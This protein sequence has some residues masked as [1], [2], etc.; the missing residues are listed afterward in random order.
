MQFAD[1][2]YEFLTLKKGQWS[3]IENDQIFRQRYLPTHV[4]V[5]LNVQGNEIIDSD[6]A[7][8]RIYFYSSGEATPFT[9]T[10]RSQ[11]TNYRYYI[12][13]D[14]QAAIEQGDAQSF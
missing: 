7:I 1:D 8:A 6:N 3:V 2:G 14:S 4:S 5:E 10:L 13:G 9:I 11:D 12:I